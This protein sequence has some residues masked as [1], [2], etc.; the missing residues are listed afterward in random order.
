MHITSRDNGNDDDVDGCDC[1]RGFYVFKRFSRNW[2]KPPSSPG[3]PGFSP[4]M[5][6]EGGRDA[7]DLQKVNHPDFPENSKPK[8]IYLNIINVKF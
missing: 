5:L 8:S 1:G 7:R 3:S 6:P 4:L 2:Q